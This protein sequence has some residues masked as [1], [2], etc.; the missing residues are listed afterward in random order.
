VRFVTYL[1]HNPDR[2]DT[3][4]TYNDT[5]AFNSLLSS[6]YF[7]HLPEYLKTSK[8]KNRVVRKSTKKLKLTRVGIGLYTIGDY[9][10]PFLP[11]YYSKNC[12]QNVFKVRSKLKGLV[13]RK[14]K[15]FNKGRYSRNRQTYRTGVYWCLY[16]NLVFILPA[17]YYCYKFSFNFGYLWYIGFFF[18]NLFV[19][20]KATNLTLSYNVAFLNFFFK[21]YRQSVTCELMGVFYRLYFIVL[22]SAFYVVT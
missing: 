13:L 5:L 12:Y 15:S 11:V 4:L 1:S 14:S 8:N 16:F 6:V 21:L 19:F 17:Y 7:F 10:E 18:I 22:A 3:L 9:Y 20:Y 2:A